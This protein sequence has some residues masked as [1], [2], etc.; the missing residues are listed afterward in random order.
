MI[1]IYVV[2]GDGSYNNIFLAKANSKKEA[3]EKVFKKHFEWQN[4]SC[5]RN[6]YAKYRKSDLTARRLDKLF[7]EEEYADDVV[8]LN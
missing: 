8:D 2:T 3:I 6:K 1:N 4:E 5:V 7:K